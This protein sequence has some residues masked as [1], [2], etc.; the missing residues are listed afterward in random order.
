MTSDIRKAAVAGKFYPGSR[1]ELEET[2]KS[3]IGP[4]P[5]SEAKGAMVPHAGYVYSGAVAGAVYGLIA[6]PDLFVILGPNHTG[7]GPVASVMPGGIWRAPSGDAQVDASL[8]QSILDRSRMLEADSAAHAFEHSIEVQLPFLQFLK[9]E[10]RFVP[11][12]LMTANPRDCREIGM[13]IAGAVREEPRG[14]LIVASSDMS[15]YESEAAAR[16]KDNAALARIIDLDPEGLLNTV[17]SR[18]ISMCGAA[19]AAAMLYACKELGASG[20]RLVRYATSGDVNGDY[21]QVVGYA[22]VIVT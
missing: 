4:G 18:Q 22:G 8:A 1:A 12:S 11:V 21:T 14:V 6:M 13:A 20:A 3:L 7:V 2:V 16:E 15:H 19:P 9:K 10:L 5:A 17:I